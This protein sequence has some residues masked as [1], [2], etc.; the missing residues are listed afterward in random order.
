L[1]YASYA[2]S[3][4]IPSRLVM[5]TGEHEGMIFPLR[6]PIVTIGRGPES[7]IQIIDTRMSRTHTMIVF[8][9]NYWFAR[10]L[11]SK[12]GTQVNAQTIQGDHPFDHGESA[13]QEHAPDTGVRG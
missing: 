4:L 12:N 8:N 9:E 6:E 11:D 3:Q 5:E 1:D 7:G 13:P 2:H 10:D